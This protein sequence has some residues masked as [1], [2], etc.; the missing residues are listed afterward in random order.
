MIGAE[1]IAAILTSGPLRRTHSRG[2]SHT[3]PTATER[4]GEVGGRPQLGVVDVASVGAN[5]PAERER[6]RDRD[7]DLGEVVLPARRPPIALERPGVADHGSLDPRDAGGADLIREPVERCGPE[8]R[9]SVPDEPQ[10][11]VDHAVDGCGRGHRPRLDHPV[12]ADRREQRHGQQQLLVRGGRALHPRQVPVPEGAVVADGHRHPPV[13]DQRVD[14]TLPH[15]L[16]RREI[17]VSD[18]AVTAHAGGSTRDRDAHDDRDGQQDGEERSGAHVRTMVRGR[19]GR[20]AGA[21][22]RRY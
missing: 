20:G 16:V 4:L 6:R 12:G 21:L 10:V 11:A 1:P 13:A 18:S 8:L 17:L 14:P 3:D 22:G 15:R 2:L 9:V 5:V 19:V 7:L